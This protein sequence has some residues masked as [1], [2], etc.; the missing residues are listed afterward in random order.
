M[1]AAIVD[2]QRADG[3]ETDA[4]AAVEWRLDPSFGTAGV[5]TGPIAA[6][7]LFVDSEDRVWLIGTHRS[8]LALARL[9]P[10]G[11]VDASFGTGGIVVVTPP[12]DHSVVGHHLRRSGDTFYASGMD[13][14]VR[15]G[16]REALLV[17]F[18]VAGAPDASFG[19]DG[20]AR[21]TGQT[22]FVRGLASP[23][24]G[25]LLVGLPSPL[26]SVSVRSATGEET[27]RTSLMHQ[28]EA[29][30]LDGDGALVTG[31]SARG[32][33]VTRLLAD[34]SLDAAF[35]AGGTVTLAGVGTSIREA[36][37]VRCGGNVY[38][39]TARLGPDGTTSDLVLARLSA[40]GAPD[41]SFGE[42]GI[43][44]LDQAAVDYATDFECVG[45]ML[46]LAGYVGPEFSVHD[47]VVLARDLDGAPSA[48]LP[49]GELRLDSP[50]MGAAVGA[51]APA[52]DGGFVGL[53]LPGGTRVF[54]VRG[55]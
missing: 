49:G 24:P 19:A 54:R 20:I 13:S 32:V 53:L 11:G 4:G 28:V 35:G 7:D 26:A 38:A 22:D 47:A 41:P 2:A 40:D 16:S 31:V 37:A 48:S 44:V 12:T 6:S 17:A 29:V 34:G 36:R 23:A 43:V 50:S 14:G 18:D 10:N 39:E 42:G 55:S 1:D 9:S 27:S 33:H 25:T 8:G 15:D 46:L 21:L 3:P 52:P 5:A 30:A 51:I 45:G